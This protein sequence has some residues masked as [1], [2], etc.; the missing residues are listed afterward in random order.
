MSEGSD[1]EETDAI[2]P[3]DPGRISKLNEL[4]ESLKLVSSQ[5]NRIMINSDGLLSVSS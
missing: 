3:R 5:F 4:L 2:E 1:S